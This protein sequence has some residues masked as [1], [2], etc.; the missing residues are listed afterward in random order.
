MLK[1]VAITFLALPLALLVWSA[2]ALAANHAAAKKTGFPTLVRWITPTN[3]LWMFYGNSIIAAS[4]FFGIRTS[5]FPRYYL[6][7]WEG[8]EQYKA[9]LELGDIFMLVTPGRNWVYIC[10]AES[11]YEILQRRSDFRRDI[12]QMSVLNV[13]GKNLST[14]DD[15]EWQKHRKV[16][17]VTFTEKNNELVWE[18]S[19]AQADGMLRY[20]NERSTQSIRTVAEDTKVFTLNVLAA[21]LFSQEYPFE[22]RKESHTKA[23]G[24]KEYREFSYQYRDSLSKILSTIIPIFVIGPTRLKSWWTPTSWKE[25]GDAVF[26]FRDYLSKLINEE[27]TQINRRGSHRQNQDLVSALVR[28]CEPLESD[29]GE[30]HTNNDKT[31]KTTLTGEE[32]I[33]NLFVYAFAGNDTTAITLAHILVNLAA[34]PQTQEWIAEEIRHYLSSQDYSQWNYQNFPKLRRCLAVVVSAAL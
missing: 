7:G 18:A 19:L 15:Q 34:N 2:R 29:I 16:T 32:I 11:V 26:N 22:S 12:K 1:T 8:N 14:T 25:A 17:A 6:F 10:N 33:S 9:H 13:Y 3:P 24:G 4:R 27:R 21:A 30:R 31:Q 20:W 5:T 28:A 23:K